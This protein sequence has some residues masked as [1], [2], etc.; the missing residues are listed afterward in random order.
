MSHKTTLFK[1]THQA[2]C[3]PNVTAATLSISG[4]FL[5]PISMQLLHWD[6]RVAWLVVRLTI[7]PA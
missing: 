5:R 4:S 2:A 6:F 3:Q 7:S 1:R